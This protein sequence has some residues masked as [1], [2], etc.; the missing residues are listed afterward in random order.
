MCVRPAL[1]LFGNLFL[2]IKC[3]LAYVDVVFTRVF[4]YRIYRYLLHQYPY[5]I[6]TRVVNAYVCYIITIIRGYFR[7]VRMVKI[8]TLPTCTR[9]WHA[10]LGGFRLRLFDGRRSGSRKSIN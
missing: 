9:L 7:Q 4:T 1:S 8:V 3:D 2:S 5:I 10:V 6:Y